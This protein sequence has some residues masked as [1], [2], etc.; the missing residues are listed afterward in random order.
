MQRARRETGLTPSVERRSLLQG[1]FRIE[2]CPRFDLAVRL[3][4][5][6][7]TGLHQINGLQPSGCD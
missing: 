2:I 3:G 7:Q 6:V 4:N 5:P 1:V